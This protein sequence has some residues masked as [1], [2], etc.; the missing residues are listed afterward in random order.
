MWVPGGIG[1]EQGVEDDE[2]FVHAGGEADL[3]WCA[4]SG[5]SVGEAANDG[6]E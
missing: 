3:G 1:F 2:Q 6:F 5:E 4:L